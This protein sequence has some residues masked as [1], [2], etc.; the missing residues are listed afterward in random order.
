MKLI[1]TRKEECR[2]TYKYTLE[3]DD[4]KLEKFNRFVEKATGHKVKVGYADIMNMMDGET[5]DTLE[6]VVNEAKGTTVGD[7][8]ADYTNAALWEAHPELTACTTEDYF[9]YWSLRRE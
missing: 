9:D 4:E 2:A 3:V 5:T 1:L 6:Q 8:L 7:M